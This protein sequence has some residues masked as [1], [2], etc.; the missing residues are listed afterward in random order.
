MKNIFRLFAFGL[1]LIGCKNQ[2]SLNKNLAT[3]T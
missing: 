1:T 3:N 2:E